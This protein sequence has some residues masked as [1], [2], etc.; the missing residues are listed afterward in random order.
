MTWSILSARFGL[1]AAFYF[2]HQGVYILT[3]RLLLGQPEKFLTTQLWIAAAV[4]A[5]VA[6][7]LFPILDRL[8][9]PS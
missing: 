4:N 3:E 5:A 9:L 2:I 1:T 8:R 6:T 7:V